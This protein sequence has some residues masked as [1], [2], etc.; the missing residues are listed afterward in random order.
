MSAHD[1]HGGV[2]MARLDNGLEVVVQPIHTAP[3][4]SV[5]CRYRVGSCD[6][7]PRQTGLSH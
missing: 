4:A 2:R 5:W 6:E 3:L 7:G 1:S